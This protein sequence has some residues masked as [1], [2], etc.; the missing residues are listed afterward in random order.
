MAKGIAHRT[1]FLYLND[2]EDEATF[3]EAVQSELAQSQFLCDRLGVALT[4]CPMRR[5]NPRADGQADEYVSEG[6]AFQTATIP[7]AT[8]TPAE[9]P[10]GE[11][12]EDAL[13]TVA[14]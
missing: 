14:A 6:W 10:T 5:R 8:D 2:Y 13:A 1:W 3:A 4:S 9:E 12:L 11:A 7:A